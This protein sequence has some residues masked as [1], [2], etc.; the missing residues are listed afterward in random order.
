MAAGQAAGMARAYQTTP[1][2]TPVVSGGGGLMNQPLDPTK[3]Y[4]VSKTVYQG[5]PAF[6]TDI[7]QSNIVLEPGAQLDN[8]VDVTENGVLLGWT[9]AV[10]D[11]NMIITSQIWGDNGSVTT[12]WN[13][14]IE[15]V[16]YLGRGMTHQQAIATAPGQYPYSLDIPGVRDDTWP[17]IRRYRSTF[18]LYAMQQGL[19]YDQVKGSKHDI[20]LVCDYTPSNKDGYSRVTLNVKNNSAN[21]RMV[22][23]FFMSRIKFQPVVQPEYTS[24]TGDAGYAGEPLIFGNDLI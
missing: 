19:T 10:N 8:P 3:S 21:P 6:R 12:L 16:T 20:W 18:S 24:A 5:L 11:P 1:I 13:D 23:Q 9:V 7:A 15:A 22:L 17:W 2:H 4:G 14:T